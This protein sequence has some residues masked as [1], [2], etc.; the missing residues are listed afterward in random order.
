MQQFVK[1]SGF[2]PVE[3]M[4][5]SWLKCVCLYSTWKFFSL[6]F[7]IDSRREQLLAQELVAQTVRAVEYTDCTSAEG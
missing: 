3:H 7:D 5:H 1:T 2:Q 4:K 6:H